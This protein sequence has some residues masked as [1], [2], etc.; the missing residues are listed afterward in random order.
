[1][2]HGGLLRDVRRTEGTRVYPDRG[3]ILEKREKAIEL[4]S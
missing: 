3:K 1:M 4:L 2:H